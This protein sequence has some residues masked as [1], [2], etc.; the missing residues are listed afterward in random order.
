MNWTNAACANI[1]ISGMVHTISVGVGTA[2]QNVRVLADT[3]SWDLLVLAKGAAC[4]DSMR[5]SASCGPFHKLFDPTQSSTVN[6][7]GQFLLASYG[8]GDILG[9]KVADSV[10]L[11]G[12][13]NPFPI[14]NQSFMLMQVVEFEDFVVTPMDGILGVGLK[15]YARDDDYFFGL[16]SKPGREPSLL[17]NLGGQHSVPPIASFCLGAPANRRGRLDFGRRTPGLS[18][19]HHLTVIGEHT[20]SVNFTGMDTAKRGYKPATPRVGFGS[21]AAQ[22][23]IALIDSGTSLIVVPTVVMRELTPLLSAVAPDCSNLNELPSLH[24]AL[25]GQWVELPA[26]YWV[27]VFSS[28]TAAVQQLGARF[29]R[30]RAEREQLFHDADAD[31]PHA[32]IQLVDAGAQKTADPFGVGGKAEPGLHCEPLFMHEDARTDK[33]LLIIMGMPLFRAYAASFSR[34]EKKISLART[35]LSSSVCETCGSPN[36][37]QQAAGSL[38]SVPSALQPQ[39]IL[40]QPT[41]GIPSR[42]VMPSVPTQARFGHSEE[43]SAP[44]LLQM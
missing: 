3:G 41:P 2:S 39:P 4:H 12:G 37:Q 33:G 10:Q 5:R 17:S 28:R 20:W 30:R 38:D 1:D 11:A 9:E 44:K 36:G 24:V 25:G 35:P 27:G 6:H 43:G 16:Y 22:Q 34:G 42:A 15:S 13:P 19:T 14:V 18:Y 7:T 29:W 31:A 8:S 21:C 26:E 40:L 23:C 32:P